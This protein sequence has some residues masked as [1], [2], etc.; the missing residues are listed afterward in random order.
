MILLNMINF[1]NFALRRA[2]KDAMKASF[3]RVAV[4][5]EGKLV[6]YKMSSQVSSCLCT[7]ISFKN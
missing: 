4:I 7:I 3:A 6:T 2:G 1:A 5:H